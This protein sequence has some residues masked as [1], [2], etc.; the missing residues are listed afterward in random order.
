VEDTGVCGAFSGTISAYA[1]SASLGNNINNMT[2]GYAIT[3]SQNGLGLLT[4]GYFSNSSPPAQFV[5]SESK[6]INST[7]SYEC[8]QTQVDSAKY[9][10]VTLANLPADF[11]S[12]RPLV[13][14]IDQ[15]AD[16]YYFQIGTDGKFTWVP[17]FADQGANFV[18]SRSF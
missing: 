3:S 7:V 15:M 1:I 13:F 9:S 6:E 12:S 10:A 5:S 17:L 18:C 16:A 4:S 11:T 2:V 14:A 8:L